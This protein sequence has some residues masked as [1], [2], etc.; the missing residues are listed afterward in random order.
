MLRS[1]GG[2][3]PVTPDE[4]APARELARTS[5]V[6]AVQ[7]WTSD[8]VLGSYGCLRISRRDLLLGIRLSS[9]LERRMPSGSP[10]AASLNEGFSNL[11]TGVV[12]ADRTR[13]EDVLVARQSLSLSRRP[14]P[15]CA[16]RPP[17]RP[18]DCRELLLQHGH[19][20]APKLEA[21]PPTVIISTP[22]S[23][24]TNSSGMA[25]G[26]KTPISPRT[27]IVPRPPA[28]MSLPWWSNFL[29]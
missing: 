26:A 27:P 13:R 16:Q 21:I 4:L 19:I 10:N 12:A 2:G 29:P 17:P 15:R 14:L 11:L 3:P 8:R 28:A 23:K 6:G 24:P 9:A 25:G 7:W 1:H 18:R 5:K 22:K 20:A